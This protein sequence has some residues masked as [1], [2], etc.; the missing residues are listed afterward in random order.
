MNCKPGDLA[1]VV[2]AHSGDDYVGVASRACLGRVVRVAILCDDGVW[3][4]EEAI[5]LG[6]IHFVHEGMRASANVI[7]DGLHDEHLR[8]ISGIPVN[9]E[10]IEE[11]TA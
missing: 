4:F 6:R 3:D 9:D 5:N 7:V 11:V 8:P 2:G 1:I 10:I